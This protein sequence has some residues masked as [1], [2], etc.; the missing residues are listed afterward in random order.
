VANSREPCGDDCPSR[1][2]LHHSYR[3][4]LFLPPKSPFNVILTNEQ[5]FISIVRTAHGDQAGKIPFEV[6]MANSLAGTLCEHTIAE[7]AKQNSRYFLLGVESNRP[8]CSTCF[9]DF[10]EG[11]SLTAYLGWPLRD[12]RRPGD[13]FGALCLRD[14]K[15]SAS[16]KCAIIN[17]P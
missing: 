2:C 13:Y 14:S 7:A 17:K 11:H 4:S 10:V 8:D 3:R 15:A 16:A 1:G 12:P 6:G 5:D 9:A